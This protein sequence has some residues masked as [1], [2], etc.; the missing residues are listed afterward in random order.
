MVSPF[1]I[2]LE[3]FEDGDPLWI[4]KNIRIPRYGSLLSGELKALA[5]VGDRTGYLE[6]ATFLIQS[7]YN[8]DWTLEQTQ[9]L[10]NHLILKAAEFFLGELNQWKDPE[11]ETDEDPLKKNS[12]GGISTGE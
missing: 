5:G 2:N 12:T 10:P 7:R 6:L 3:D 11:P 1:P 4:G 8:H 9:Q